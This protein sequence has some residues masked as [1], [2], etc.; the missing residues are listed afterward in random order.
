MGEIGEGGA[1]DKGD[2]GRS[3]DDTFMFCGMRSG[4]EGEVEGRGVGSL[5]CSFTFAIFVNLYRKTRTYVSISLC[6]D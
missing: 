1:E 6:P 2:E 3:E 5:Y 4:L